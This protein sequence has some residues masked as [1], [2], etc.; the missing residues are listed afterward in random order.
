MNG[1]PTWWYWGANRAQLTQLRNELYADGLITNEASL[2]TERRMAAMEAIWAS[3]FPRSW[4]LRRR[5]ARDLRRDASHRTDE[6]VEPR[7]PTKAFPAMIL[8][9]RRPPGRHR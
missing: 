8:L 7:I 5:L 3:R 4:L 1:P 2:R 9:D 6:W